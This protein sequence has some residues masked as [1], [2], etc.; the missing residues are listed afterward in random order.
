MAKSYVLTPSATCN[1]VDAI[2]NQASPSVS[3]ANRDPPA[4]DLAE[5]GVRHIDEQRQTGHP[6][7][8]LELRTQVTV[9]EVQHH[10][11]LPSRLLP[12]DEHVVTIHGH[13]GQIR[14]RSQTI[15]MVMVTMVAEDL[16]DV[17][18]YTT[19]Y[20][21]GCRRHNS[22]QRFSRLILCAEQI[23]SRDMRCESSRHI[24]HLILSDTIS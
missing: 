23:H 18:W 22:S 20:G 14:V 13:L 1:S 9:G 21:R 12:V 17:W 4:F 11:A 5:L 10:P 24:K 2:D 8:H 16:S 3:C 7:T 19:Q 6:H 15:Y